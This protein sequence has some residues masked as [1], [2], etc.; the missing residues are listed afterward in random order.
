M[1]IS[2]HTYQTFFVGD[3]ISVKNSATLYN[4]LKIHTIEE[5]EILFRALS[6]MGKENI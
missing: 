6:K 3:Y 4:L 2:E 5:L 1:K